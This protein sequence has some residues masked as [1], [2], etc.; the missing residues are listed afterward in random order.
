MLFSSLIIMVRRYGGF[1]TGRK[2]HVQPV[3]IP[4]PVL[5]VDVV[6]RGPLLFVTG[7]INGRLALEHVAVNPD[8]V[9]DDFHALGDAA[10]DELRVMYALAPFDWIP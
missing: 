9:P 10:M 1:H 5:I 3:A 6:P 2:A 8:P 7:R 4:V